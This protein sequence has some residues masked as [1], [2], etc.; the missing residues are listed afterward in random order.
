V[1]SDD[2]IAAVRE[3]L[4]DR[5]G[6]PPQEVDNLLEAARFR[7][8]ARK[9]GLTDV[10]LQGQHIR[11][12]PVRLRESQQ[13]RLDRLYPKA[14]YKVAAETLL[15]PVPKT[16]PLGGQPLRDLDLLKWCTDLVEAMFLE[17]ARAAGAR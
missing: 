9:A 14:I 11:F 5:Y 12:A 4:V 8:H 1:G 7:V 13:V 10:A 3:E 17:P 15:V 2:D 6:R 16:K